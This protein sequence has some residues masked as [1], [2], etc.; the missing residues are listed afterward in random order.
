MPG[1]IQKIF[2]LIDSITEKINKPAS[3]LV[4]VIM[5]CIS[6]EVISR[7]VFNRPTNWVWPI[8][9]QLFSLFILVSGVYAMAR[10]DHIRIEIIYDFFPAWMKQFVRILSIFCILVFLGV[11]VWQSAWMAWDSILTG[12]TNPGSFRILPLYPIK[13]LI[14]IFSFLFLLQGVSVLCRRKKSDKKQEN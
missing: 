8:S 2:N 5:G 7:Y 10:E 4:M 1:Q 14:P 11:L 6:F 9:R 12:E 13:S 3:L